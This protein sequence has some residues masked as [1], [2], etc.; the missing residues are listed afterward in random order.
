[1]PGVSICI[2]CMQEL[3]KSQKHVGS[4][5][6]GVVK[7]CEQSRQCWESNPC[8]RAASALSHRAVSPVG[9]VVLIAP[10]GSFCG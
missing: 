3:C 9:L 5:E 10:N 4:L 7:G 1:M 8:V 2:T 6:T